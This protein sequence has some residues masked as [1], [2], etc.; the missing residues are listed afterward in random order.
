[1][2]LFDLLKPKK[3]WQLVRT[4]YVDVVVGANTNDEEQGVLNFYL[5]ETEN[6]ERKI[7]WKHSVKRANDNFDAVNIYT[8]KIYPWLK[9]M[10]YSD[11]PSYWEVVKDKKE[12]YVK[13]L[14][15][16]LLRGR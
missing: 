7:E 11:I 13:I 4:F 3:D 8:Q 10:D 1:M 5:F 6:N 12:K 16:Q 9:G 14:Y 15:R 2:G